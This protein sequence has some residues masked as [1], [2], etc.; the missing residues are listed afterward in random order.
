MDRE[1]HPELSANLS[2]FQRQLVASSADM[3]PLKVWQLQDLSLQAAQRVA[4]AEPDEVL[5]LITG[6]AQNFPSVV[7]TRDA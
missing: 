4:Q 3:A 2:A 6:L 7:S 1:L 5:R